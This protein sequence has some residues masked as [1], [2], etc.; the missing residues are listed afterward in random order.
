MGSCLSINN[1]SD[2]EETRNQQ[3]KALT[4]ETADD[5]TYDFTT[6]KVLKVYDGDSLTIGALYN[7]QLVKF[8]VRI[9]GIDCDEMKGG[10]TVTRKNAKLAKMFVEHMV[11]NKIIT[12]NVLNNKTYEGKNMKEKF[13][14]LLSII[15]IDNKNVADE[16][17][18]YG[19]ARKYFGEKK[20]NTHLTPNINA[21]NNIIN[22]F[23][24]VVLN[25]DLNYENNILD[26]EPDKCGIIYN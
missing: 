21:I 13:G 6:A 12:I 15:T 26:I 23:K 16:L 19:L 11:L 5:V 10:T 8:N 17:I 3:L 24:T 9:F 4:Y 7:N 18:H 20:D 22:D 2:I 1:Y 14:R 25:D